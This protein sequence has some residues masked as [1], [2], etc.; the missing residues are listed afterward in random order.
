MAKYS[1]KKDDFVMII[2]GKDKGKTAQVIAIN[3]AKHRVLVEGKD[4]NTVNKKAV[5]ARKATDKGGLIEQPGSV[6]ISNVMPICSACGK[7]TRVGRGEKD[8]EKIRICKKCGAELITKK[9]SPARKGK[10][11]KAETPDTGTTKATVRKR[12]K[13]AAEETAEVK[14]EAKAQPEAEV[15]A[16]PKAEAKAEVT[17]EVKA[18]SK[19]EVAV[20]K[21]APAKK[22]EPKAEATVKAPAKKADETKPAPAK[23]TAKASAADTPADKE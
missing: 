1:I 5:K 21:K 3:A 19:T 23:K 11:Q 7:P 15:K 20:E 6:D 13:P 18:E 9:A 14:E 12:V 16:E 4:L 22:T 17:E 10:A 8:G 2:A